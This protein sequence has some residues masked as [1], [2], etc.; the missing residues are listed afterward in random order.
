MTAVVLLTE[1]YGTEL[2]NLPA[3]VSPAFSLS[4]LFGS[5]EELPQNTLLQ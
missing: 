2:H 1:N 5:A 4:K 3:Y